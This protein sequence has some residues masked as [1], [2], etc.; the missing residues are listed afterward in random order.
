[1]LM[2]SQTYIKLITFQEGEGSRS[3][4]IPA[5]NRWFVTDQPKFKFKVFFDRATL[6]HTIKLELVMAHA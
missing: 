5:T 3:G 6:K 4:S 2:K 1:M